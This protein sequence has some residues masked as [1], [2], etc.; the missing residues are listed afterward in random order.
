MC[1]RA[2]ALGL[3]VLAV[4]LNDLFRAAVLKPPPPTAAGLGAVGVLELLGV[5]SGGHG[6]LLCGGGGC[7]A[8]KIGA[9]PP[10]VKS[11]DTMTGI[12]YSPIKHGS[13]G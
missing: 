6:G 8:H 1:L 3:A 5:E 11:V 2:L 7:H 9:I 4:E 10:R 12:T 13:D